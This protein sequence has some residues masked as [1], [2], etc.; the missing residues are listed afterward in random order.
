MS[1]FIRYFLLIFALLFSFQIQGQ[2]EKVDLPQSFAE[3]LKKAEEQ[4][5][6][7]FFEEFVNML[8]WL[9]LLIGLMFFGMWIL[10]KMTASRL[11]Q[12]NKSSAIKILET[13]PLTPK[14][15]IYI[16]GVF[17]KAVTIAD[18]INGVTLL[19]EQSISEEL[20]GEF[21]IS[22]PSFQ[23]YLQEKRDS[24]QD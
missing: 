7:R 8:I 5:D 3:E 13:R 21:D 9:G 23:H 11:Q 1:R 22:S 16:L 2:E 20:K 12:V 17:G 19:N 24:D 18:S 15:T 4:G 6:S 14:T 10:K